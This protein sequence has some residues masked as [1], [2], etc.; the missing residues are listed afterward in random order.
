MSTLDDELKRFLEQHPEVAHAMELWAASSTKYEEAMRGFLSMPRIYS[1][2]STAAP[3]P[4]TTS[5]P[6]NA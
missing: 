1:G 2:G 5:L 4:P 3:P 6:N